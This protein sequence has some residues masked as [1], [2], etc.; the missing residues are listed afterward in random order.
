MEVRKHDSCVEIFYFFVCQYFKQEKYL[1]SAVLNMGWGGGNVFDHSF[2][3][4]LSFMNTNLGKH[5][6]GGCDTRSKAGHNEP[7]FLRKDHSVSAKKKKR[8]E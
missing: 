1:E 8:P 3:F 6:G 5:H 2:S 4:S 7:A